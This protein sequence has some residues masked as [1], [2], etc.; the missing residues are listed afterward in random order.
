MPLFG[1]VCPNEKGIGMHVF[2]ILC[3]NDT[4]SGHEGIALQLTMRKKFEVLGDVRPN[5]IVIDKNET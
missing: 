5:A 1:A 4:N 3:S 2:L